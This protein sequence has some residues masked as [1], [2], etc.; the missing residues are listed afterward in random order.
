MITIEVHD[1]DVLAAFNRLLAVNANMT[2]AMKAIGERLA[3]TTKR[4]FETST[5]PD[6]SRWAPNSR[7]TYEMLARSRGKFRKK[8]GKLSGGKGGAGLLATKKP[9]IGESKALS[10]TIDYRVDAT[11]VTIFSPMEYAAVQQFG[12]VAGALGRN[13]RGSPIPWGNIPA[14]PFLGVSAQDKVEV[15][16]ILQEALLGAAGAK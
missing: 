6:G 12:A 10:T 1:Q 16:E 13:K 9:L 4:R 7:V 8:D 5:A 2:P 11:G 3:E 15:L 14:R